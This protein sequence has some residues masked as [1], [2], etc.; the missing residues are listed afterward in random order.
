MSGE[1]FYYFCILKCLILL[2][3]LLLFYCKMFHFGCTKV[4]L[5]AKA[6]K[7]IVSCQVG[8]LGRRIRG[9]APPI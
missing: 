6:P 4:A 7:S 1:S 5:V 9:R 2:L 8:T 3:Y